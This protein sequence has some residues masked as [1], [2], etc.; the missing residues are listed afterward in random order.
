MTVSNQIAGS[1]LLRSWTDL[2]TITDPGYIDSSSATDETFTY[3]IDWGDGTTV[4]TGSVEIDQLGSLPSGGSPSPLT[5]GSID[6][7]HTYANDGRY[8]VTVTVTDNDGDATVETFEVQVMIRL[9]DVNYS[10]T[11]ATLTFTDPIDAATITHDSVRVM[12]ANRVY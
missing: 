3:S 4:A 9:L 7:S 5:T 6:A 12:A 1:Q 2:I 8:N 10:D 11:T